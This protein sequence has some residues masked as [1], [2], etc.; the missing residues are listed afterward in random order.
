MCVKIL[1]DVVRNILLA[2]ILDGCFEYV[3]RYD[4]FQEVAYEC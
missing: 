4:G 2:A 1:H 3:L